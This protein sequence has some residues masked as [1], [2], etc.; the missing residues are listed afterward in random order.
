MVMKTKL[1]H[2]GTLAAF[3]VFE[4]AFLVDLRGY[5]QGWAEALS[6]VGVAFFVL[7]LV[8]SLWRHEINRKMAGVTVLALAVVIALSEI[9]S[10]NMDS[11]DLATLFL[12]A[13]AVAAVSVF[14]WLAIKPLKGPSKGIKQFSAWSLFANEFLLVAYLA[15]N[16]SVVVFTLLAIATASLGYSF[17]LIFRSTTKA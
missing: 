13:V 12:H 9:Q 11:T 5:G 6:F 1:V 16:E 2:T 10:S 8:Y 4:I 14:Y 15:S 17:W 3:V 7:G